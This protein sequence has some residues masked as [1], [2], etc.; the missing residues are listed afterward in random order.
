MFQSMGV[1]AV[2]MLVANIALAGTTPVPIV[3]HMPA[4]LP[5]DACIP[6]GVGS[7]EET[8]TSKGD[9]VMATGVHGAHATRCPDPRFPNLA[10]TE[11]LPPDEER[12]LPSARCVPHGAKVGDELT[13]PAYGRATVVELGTGNGNCPNGDMAKVVGTALYRASKGQ[14]PSR[15]APAHEPTEQEIQ[16]EYERLVAATVPVQEYHVRHILLTTR[17]DALAALERI[18]AG[19]TFA[20]VAAEL[21]IDSGSKTKGGDLGWNVPSSFIPEFSQS[22]VSLAPSGLVTEPVKT[23]FGWHVIELLETKR[24]KDSFPP[25]ALVKAPIAARLKSRHTAVSASAPVPAKAVCRKMVAPV[26]AATDAGAGTKRTVVAEIRVENG[27]VAE[28]LRLSGP[29]ELHAAV[30]DALNKYECDRLDRPTIA[31]QSFEF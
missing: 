19:R 13:I 3:I 7:G 14:D 1:I 6:D 31:V 12:K 21:S 20:D 4:Y 29:G 22:M 10:T 27:R 17:A 18:H 26:L 2:S 5:G 30:T 23:K 11:K 24:G 9:A 28:I 25:L 15:P 16:R 8:R